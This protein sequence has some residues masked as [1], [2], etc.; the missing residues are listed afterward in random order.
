MMRLIAAIPGETNPV[1]DKVEGPSTFG[2]IEVAGAS[3]A[4]VFWGDSVGWTVGVSVEGTPVIGS[5]LTLNIAFVEFYRAL[6]Q[7]ALGLGG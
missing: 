3:L 6:Q 4:W 2:R 7:A 5:G 1:V